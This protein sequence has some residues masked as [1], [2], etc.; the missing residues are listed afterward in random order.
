MKKPA[1]GGLLGGA[2]R[3]C[4]RSAAIHAFAMGGEKMDCHVVS[5]LTMTEDVL[6]VK[7]RIVLLI[8][9]HYL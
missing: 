4:E 2:I 3:H 6:G 9:P 8:I 7:K 1:G 5:L